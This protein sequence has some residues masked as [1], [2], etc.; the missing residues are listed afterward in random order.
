MH[1]PLLAD[2]VSLLVPSG[3]RKYG[4]WYWSWEM[5]RIYIW[6]EGHWLLYLLQR[7]NPWWL[8]IVIVLNICATINHWLLY[9][10]QRCN[11]WWLLIVIVLNISATINHWFLY[12]LERCNP[13]WLLIVIVL[14]ISA[15]INHWL[16]YLLQ[17]CN[18]WWLLIGIVLN[19]SATINQAKIHLSSIVITNDLAMLFICQQC[20]SA[21]KSV[22]P[23]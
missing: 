23:K 16:L 3:Y 6:G 17:R 8:L 9:L 22:R 14:N 7:C 15:T 13:W 11:P 12:L 19:I 21:E 1:P 2:L 4:S 10:L 20:A 18:P 5:D